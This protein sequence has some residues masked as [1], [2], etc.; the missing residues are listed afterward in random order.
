MTNEMNEIATALNL[1]PYVENGRL[2][3]VG[4]AGDCIKFWAAQ[5]YDVVTDHIGPT[6]KSWSVRRDGEHYAM[7]LHADGF[8][9][10]YSYTRRS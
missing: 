4:P 6:T 10:A 5:G 9:E 2:K 1:V 3:V 8:D 7:I